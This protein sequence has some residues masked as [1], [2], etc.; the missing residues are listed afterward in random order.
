M[1]TA[2][3]FVKDRWMMIDARDK[4]TTERTTHFIFVKNGILAQWV[5][6]TNPAPANFELNSCDINLQES[7]QTN[8]FIKE[9]CSTVLIE[10]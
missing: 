10:S 2:H 9:V 3:N 7:V 4:V 8:W 1:L 6:I 5:Y